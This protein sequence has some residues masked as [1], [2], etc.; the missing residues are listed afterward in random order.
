M[1]KRGICEYCQSTDTDNTVINSYGI[2]DIINFSPFI[3]KKINSKCMTPC[4][5]GELAL[6][7]ENKELRMS[8]YND[9]NLALARTKISYCPMCGRKL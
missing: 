7:I 3:F 2:A 8:H 4:G 1:K 9:C 5:T 6:R